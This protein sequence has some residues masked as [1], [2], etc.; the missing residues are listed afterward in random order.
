MEWNLS[1]EFD[2]EGFEIGMECCQVWLDRIRIEFVKVIGICL[3]SS[4]NVVLKLK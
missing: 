2:F 4:L 1:K 3:F